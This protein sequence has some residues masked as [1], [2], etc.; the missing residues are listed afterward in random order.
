M[1]NEAVAVTS[2]RVIDFP[3]G[4][5]ATFG[6]ID[7]DDTNKN[8]EDQGFTVTPTQFGANLVGCN[9]RK[10]DFVIFNSRV[11]GAADT[12]ALPAWFK[13][14]GKVQ[15]FGDDAT[16]T[17]GFHQLD[18]TDDIATVSLDFLALWINVQG[19]PSADGA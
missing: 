1:A 3:G 4:I 17:D 14:T 18:A 11:G 13:S 8:Y 12:A 9:G 2:V 19:S 7:I 15:L 16:Q 10:P 6:S 5:R